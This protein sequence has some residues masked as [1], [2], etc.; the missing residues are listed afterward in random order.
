ML[1]YFGISVCSQPN[2]I[3]IKALAFCCLHWL[4]YTRER[5]NWSLRKKVLAPFFIPY[6]YFSLPVLI[7]IK[8]ISILFVQYSQHINRAEE[9]RKKLVVPE[10]PWDHQWSSQS[11]PASTQDY[12]WKIEQKSKNQRY[13][14]SSVTHTVQ[15]NQAAPLSYNP[16]QI[17]NK[18]KR[19]VNHHMDDKL[20][21]IDKL[22]LEHN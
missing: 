6:I 9:P 1:I 17:G 8:Y 3:E 5:L 19:K 14:M 15:H 22:S 13:D 18:K 16:S 11:C 12:T 20:V 21:A 10:S 2:I 4:V 7:G